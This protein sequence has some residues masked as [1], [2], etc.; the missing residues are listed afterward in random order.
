LSLPDPEAGPSGTAPLPPEWLAARA[1]PL[2]TFRRGTRFFRVHRRDHDAVYFG[3]AIDPEIGQRP[4]P[5][6]RFDSLAGVFGV[7][8]LSQHLE[9]AFVETLLRNPQRRFVS[10]TEVMSR[11]VSELT[12]NRDLKLVNLH[13]RGLSRVGTTNAIS[14]GPYAPCW[15][16]SDY[17]WWHRDEP[18]GIAYTSRHNPR[19]ICYAIFERPGAVFT[20]ATPTAF[21]RMV[22][23][24]KE[25][26]RRYEKILVKP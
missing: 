5:T 22:P 20:A 24:V 14:T 1:L 12:C 17:L 10:E 19:Q 2:V 6:H 23:M 18:D 26:L 21:A 15:A 4:R 16:W 3:P 25:L 11:A 8:Y 13:G 7:I 9:G